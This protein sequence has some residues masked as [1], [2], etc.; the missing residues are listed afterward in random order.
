MR[1]AQCVSTVSS[2]TK[3]QRNTAVS[4]GQANSKV[5]QHL[6][7]LKRQGHPCILT[8]PETIVAVK[9]ILRVDDPSASMPRVR[10]IGTD[11]EKKD[12]PLRLI[13]SVDVPA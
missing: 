11:D 8:L 3:R 1:P 12:V 5:Y 13:E 4:T 6:L 7:E 9:D 2:V 10:L